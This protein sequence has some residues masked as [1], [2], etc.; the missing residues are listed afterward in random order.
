[1]ETLKAKA[2]L[3][4]KQF[5][6]SFDIEAIRACDTIGAFDEAYIARIYGFKDKFD[7]YDS[8]GAKRWLHKI[9]VP[10]VA[11][12]ARDDPFVEETALPTAADVGELA[13]VRLI[14]H[15]Y[16]GH[17]GF[18]TTQSNMGYEG[19]ESEVP[20]H[21]WLGEELARVIEHIHNKS[22]AP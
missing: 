1:M 8:S 2:E 12:N 22:T 7:Y 13:P 17:C 11:I 14:Y 10:A 16:G 4:H 18:Y 3:E 15:K 9:R 20:S 19:C 5:P 6:H 21:G